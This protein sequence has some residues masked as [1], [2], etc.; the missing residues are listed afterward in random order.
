M[1]R[2]LRLTELHQ[3]EH[4]NAKA[5]DI[6]RLSTLSIKLYR[7][8]NPSEIAAASLL[9]SLTIVKLGKKSLTLKTK[10]H[11]AK[12]D[13]VLKEFWNQEV[14]QVTSIKYELLEKPLRKLKKSII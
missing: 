10:E 14:S 2:F 13:A 4:I 7:E 5:H 9:L 8:L 11:K 12:E 1:E 3:T 6:L